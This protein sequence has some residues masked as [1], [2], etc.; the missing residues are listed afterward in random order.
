MALIE[1]YKGYEI[2]DGPTGGRYDANNNLVDQVIAYTCTRPDG[3]TLNS[4]KSSLNEA[5]KAIDDE[6][7]PPKNTGRIH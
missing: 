3:S 5:R 2:H 7:S 1:N 4:T 6:L